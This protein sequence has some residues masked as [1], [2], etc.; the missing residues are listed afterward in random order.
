[1]HTARVP[2]GASFDLPMETRPAKSL[3]LLAAFPLAALVAVASLGGILIPSTYA[4]ESPNWTAQAV[5]QDWVDLLVAVPWLFLSGLKALR[6]SRRAMFLLAGAMLYTFYEFVIYGFAVRFNAFFLLY[7]AT[8]GVCFFALVGMA[9]QLFREDVRHWYAA[10]PPVR[11]AALFLIGVGA[12]FALVWLGEIVPALLEGRVPGS[13]GEA[14][15]LTNPVYV[16]DLSVVLPLHV[17]AGVALLRRRPLGY[18]LAPAVLAF[19]V[20]MS[21]SI[22]GM[23]LVMRERGVEASLAVAAGMLIIC[24]ATAAVLGSLLRGL[25][26]H[27]TER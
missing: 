16:M 4:Q 22:A 25:G 18:V 23:M 20:L 26:P 3:P 1:M 17:I 13:I 8:L 21:L 10:A 12:L 14:G 19:G 27:P 7:C 6:G 11:P 24:V 5:G 2:L 9:Y 15:V